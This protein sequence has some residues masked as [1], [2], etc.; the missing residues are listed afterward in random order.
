MG[1]VFL[2]PRCLLLLVSEGL[3]LVV[4]FVYLQR[5]VAPGVAGQ[6]PVQCG[7]SSKDDTCGSRN[8]RR[9]GLQRTTVGLFSM[10]ETPRCGTT[11]KDDAGDFFGPLGRWWRLARGGNEMIS[12]RCGGLRLDPVPEGG[13][14]LRAVST[15]IL[16]T[17][18]ECGAVWRVQR[19]LRT[20]ERGAC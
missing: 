8:L 20:I 2:K 4:G 5:S 6:S 16:E 7:T 14:P 1:V 10:A 12:I 9:L 11:S 18:Q 13:A 19:S 17:S 3:L 15:V